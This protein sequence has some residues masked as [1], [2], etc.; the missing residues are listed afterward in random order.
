MKFSSVPLALF[1]AST[2][3]LPT[4]EVEKRAAVNSG[5]LDLIGELEGFRSNF[6]TDTVGHQ[7]IGR[8]PELC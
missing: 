2:V 4:T 5:A 1:A 7:A 3:A 6:Y 8:F